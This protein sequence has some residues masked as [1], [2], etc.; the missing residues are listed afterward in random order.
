MNIDFSWERSAVEYARL[1]EKAIQN[2][3]DFLKQRSLASS[4]TT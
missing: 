3:K 1:Y 4:D 2:R